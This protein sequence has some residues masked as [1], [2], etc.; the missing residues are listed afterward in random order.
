M[1]KWPQQPTLCSNFDKYN[2][3]SKCKTHD[4]YYNKT[5]FLCHVQINVCSLLGKQQLPGHAVCCASSSCLQGSEVSLPRNLNCFKVKLF[6]PFLSPKRAARSDPSC[7]AF[8]HLNFNPFKV[9]P[10]S[11]RPLIR[12]LVLQHRGRLLLR[13]GFNFGLLHSWGDLTETVTGSFGIHD[14]WVNRGGHNGPLE[15]PEAPEGPWE[16]DPD[17]RD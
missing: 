5:R 3:P 14:V 17:Y 13:G 11:S 7:P 9:G 2:L 16:R 4:Y 12:P 8:K 10:V 1:I 15:T 6:G